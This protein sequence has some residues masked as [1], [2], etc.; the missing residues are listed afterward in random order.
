VVPIISTLMDM[1]LPS[2]VEVVPQEMWSGGQQRRYSA[3]GKLKSH[4]AIS[5]LSI[6]EN[7]TLGFSLGSGFRLWAS[8]CVSRKNRALTFLKLAIQNDGFR[9]VAHRTDVV[10]QTKSRF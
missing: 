1:G 5:T 6:G 7:S 10:S 2:S 4:P 8:G 3:S 9:R